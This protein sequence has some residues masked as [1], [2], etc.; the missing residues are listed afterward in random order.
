VSPFP[1]RNSECAGADVVTVIFADFG[2]LRGWF[3]SEHQKTARVRVSGYL[4]A[5]CGRY[6]V[7]CKEIVE[8]RTADRAS[9]F[10][11]SCMQLTLQRAELRT[12]WLH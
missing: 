10:S 8:Y 9:E 4:S 3:F 5:L 1:L 2:S 12:V 7:T 6:P 11:L